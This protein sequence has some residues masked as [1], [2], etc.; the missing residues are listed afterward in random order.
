M[1]TCNGLEKAPSNQLTLALLVWSCDVENPEEKID[2]L[3]YEPLRQGH[4]IQEQAAHEQALHRVLEGQD[5]TLA[6]RHRAWSAVRS[7]VL[8]DC[9]R[10]ATWLPG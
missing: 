3:G 7:D 8:E 5:G 10:Y 2:K 4:V 6:Q 9:T 1:L